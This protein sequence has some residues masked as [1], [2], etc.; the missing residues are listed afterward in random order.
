VRRPW[1]R[2][3]AAV[4][5]VAALGSAIASCATQA[6]LA[7]PDCGTEELGTLSLI[8]QSVHDAT[9]IPCLKTLAAGWSFEQLEVQQDHSAMELASDR[10]G[11]H[12]LTVTLARTCDIRGAVQIPSDEPQTERFENVVRVSPSYVGTRSYVFTGGC[13]TY[14]FQLAT[15]R[16]SVLLNEATLMVGFIARAELRAAIERDTDGLVNDGP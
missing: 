14:R 10:A 13:V 12:A 1:V 9:M 5:C 4:A 2:R 6:T 7:R 8:A 3:A 11:D 16:P 15:S